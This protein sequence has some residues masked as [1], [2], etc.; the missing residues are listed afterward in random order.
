M[1]ES[2]LDSVKKSLGLSADYDAFDHDIVM[3]VNSAF[4]TL[5]QLG[6]GPAEGF[7][8]TG[9]DEEWASFLGSDP[10]LNSVK[11]FVYLDVRMLFDPPSTS[12]MISAMEKRIDEAKWR[13]NV[14]RESKTYAPLKERL[15]I[16]GGIP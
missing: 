6:V 7:E 13:I 15:P 16:D 11:T 2:I 8:I 5:H 10:V 9:A 14:Y 1:I 4:S 3:H 12:Y